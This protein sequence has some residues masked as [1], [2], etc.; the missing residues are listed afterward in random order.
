MFR[1]TIRELALLTVIVAMGIAW[2]CDR[3]LA[4]NETRNIHDLAHKQLLNK[5]QSEVQRAADESGV[6]I[7]LR[8]PG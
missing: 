4:E 1:F 6:T 5:L 8:R 7:K 3:W 2:W